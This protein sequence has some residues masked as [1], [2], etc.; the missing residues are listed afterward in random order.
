MKDTFWDIKVT[1]FTHYLCSM[2]YMGHLKSLSELERKIHYGSKVNNLKQRCQTHPPHR[3]WGQSVGLSVAQ[4]SPMCQNQPAA[5]VQCRQLQPCTWV[6]SRAYAACSTH[7]S[8]A[9]CTSSSTWGQS[10]GLIQ[11]NLGSSM[12][13]WLYR[14]ATCS[15]CPRLAHHAT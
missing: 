9:L 2:L 11:T 10:S 8:L 6:S 15:T 4:M 12:Q 5:P 14:G 13:E 3:T 1:I 7:A